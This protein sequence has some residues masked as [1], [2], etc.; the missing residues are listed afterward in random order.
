MPVS[1]DLASGALTTASSTI[2]LAPRAREMDVELG[3]STALSRKSSLRLGVARAFD[4]GHVSGATDTAGFVTL[5][6]R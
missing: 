3:W 2:D 6:L 4:A 5:H 1:Y